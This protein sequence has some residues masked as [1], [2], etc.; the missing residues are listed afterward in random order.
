MAILTF[1]EEPPRPT[2]KQVIDRPG[3]VRMR[4]MAEIRAELAPNV[5]VT[6]LGNTSKNIIKD[7]FI[8][9]RIKKEPGPE[10][11]IKK[12]LKESFLVSLP[13]KQAQKL[14]NK[15]SFSIYPHG[16]DLKVNKRKTNYEITY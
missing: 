14:F 4:I 2:P 1:S 16:L 13:I 12:E 5:P 10:D 9:K 6:L 8:V 7:V 11:F 15:E 3:Y